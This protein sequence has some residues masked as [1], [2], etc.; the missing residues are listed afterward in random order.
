HPLCLPKVIVFLQLLHSYGPYYFDSIR[1]WDKEK[2][3]LLE[4]Y[5]YTL[6]DNL[7]GKF[8]FTYKEGKPFLRVLDTAIK[9][10]NPQESGK[11]KIPE[12]QLTENVV[13]TLETDEQPAVSNQRIG[14]VFNFHQSAYPGF[15]I[16][17]VV[18]EAN[19]NFTAYVGKVEKL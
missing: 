3:K 8:E 5:G 11:K 9:R 19:E 17:A 12:P 15:K 6:S 13:E 1:N 16:E 4:A 14:V 2:N 7:E 18:G 10:V